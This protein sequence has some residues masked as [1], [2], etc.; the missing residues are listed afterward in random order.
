MDL[1]PYV[2][3]LRRE[4]AVAA[5]AGGP[6]A[7]A[8]AERLTGVLESATRLT[9]LEALS[10]AAD[11]ITG[12]LAPGSVEV[13]LRGGDPSFVVTPPLAPQAASSPEITRE[14]APSPAA[15]EGGTARMTLRLPEHLKVRVEEAAGRQGVSVNAWLVRAI[16]AA[17]DSGAATGPGDRTQQVQSGRDY[18]GWVR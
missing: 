16:S 17:F 1:M 8:L 13:R 3:N 6:E 2:D 14:A 18:T 4:L 15:E 10:A 12:E 7:R 11:E 9:L 5:E